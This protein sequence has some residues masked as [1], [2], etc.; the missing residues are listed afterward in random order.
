MLLSLLL[1]A[2]ESISLYSGPRPEETAI[3][4][5][6]ITGC[7][8][9]RNCSAVALQAPTTGTD[10][11]TDHL[12]AMIEIP[13][14]THRPPLVVLH[15]P[16]TLKNRP[17]LRIFVDQLTVP[18]P[19]VEVGSVRISG[20]QARQIVQ[21]MRKGQWMYLRDS[22]G[23]AVARTSLA[24][25]T[26]ALVRI[27][28]QQ[29]KLDT[30]DALV[31]RG[32]RIAYDD[33][34]GYRVSLSRPALVANS[35][36]NPQ[37]AFLDHNRVQCDSSAAEDSAKPIVVRLDSKNSMAI[38]P[39]ACG[40]GAY[41]RYANIMIVDDQGKVHAAE[42]DY[43]N[44]ITGDGPSSVQAEVAWLE[45]ERILESATRFRGTGDCGRTDR[46]IWDGNKFRMSEQLV[47]PECRGSYNRIRVLKADVADR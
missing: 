5:N 42:F 13:L 32:K 37:P 6:W 33:L 31:H 15:F 3:Y 18:L 29:G 35:P 9:I 30:P 21:A 47:M 7:D 19:P 11:D 2:I 22:K 27:D 14:A 8:N 24:G 4:Q 17:D 39:W 44:G 23:E 34:P 45:K 16:S 41:V 46:Y 28:E 20:G 10:G 43:D 12:E 36:T 38:V 1:T 40:N 26:A 25:L